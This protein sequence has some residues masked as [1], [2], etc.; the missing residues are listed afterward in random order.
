[1]KIDN[2]R[3]ANQTEYMGFQMEDSNFDFGITHH[4]TGLG[5]LKIHSNDSGTEYNVPVADILKPMAEWR[6]ERR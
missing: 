5:K 4:S 6:I 3:L 2:I 1:M